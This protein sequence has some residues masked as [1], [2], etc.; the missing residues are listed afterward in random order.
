MRAKKKGYLVAR[1]LPLR[2]FI[3]RVIRR[4]AEHR[5]V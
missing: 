4:L 3:T 1:F 5:A 2:V